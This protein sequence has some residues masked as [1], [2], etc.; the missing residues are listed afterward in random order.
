[1]FARVEIQIHLMMVA[2]TIRSHLQDEIPPDLSTGVN[3]VS[4][5][6]FIMR[7][8][9]ESVAVTGTLPPPSLDATVG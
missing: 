6:D 4:K 5:H 1:M 2:G 7:P 8:E 9:I 3:L